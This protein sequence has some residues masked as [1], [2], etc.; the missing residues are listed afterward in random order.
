M[1]LASDAALLQRSG[2]VS[3]G[4]GWAVPPGRTKMP[5]D[6]RRP[7]AA[8]VEHVSAAKA[9]V[10][11]DLFAMPGVHTLGIGYKRVGGKLTD[12]VSLVVYVDQ[13][14]SAEQLAPGWLVPRSIEVSGTVGAWAWV[15]DARRGGMPPRDRVPVPCTRGSAGAIDVTWPA[16]VHDRNARV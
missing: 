6:M 10:E 15:A 11:A 7:S 1:Y 3:P 4:P 12:E 14:V 13:K 9:Q 5:E 2:N 8:E 16:E